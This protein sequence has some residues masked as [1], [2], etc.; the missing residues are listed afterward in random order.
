MCSLAQTAPAARVERH[1]IYV[2]GEYSLINSDFFGDNHS[3]NKSAFTIYGDYLIF[4]GTFPVSLDVNFTKDPNTEQDNRHLSSWMFGPKVGY[5]MGRWEPFVKAG[6]G[7]GHLTSNDV[8]T[9]KQD[10]EH[11]AVGF[12][13][14]LEYRLT[15]RITLRPVDFTYERWNFSPN[16]LSPEILGFGLSYR[17]H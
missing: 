15:G 1:S 12:G 10:G 5:R 17:I 8:L 14:G 7:L 2:G 3:L 6:A 4:N 9:Y 13:G 16:A 11:F